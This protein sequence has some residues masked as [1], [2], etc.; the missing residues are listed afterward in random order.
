MFQRSYFKVSGF[1][2]NDKFYFIIIFVFDEK[3]SYYGLS[4]ENKMLLKSKPF[5]EK[6]N[7]FY[8]LN[9]SENL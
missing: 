3:R 8:D 7:T 1:L 9:W 6:E 2:Q 4:P 5:S